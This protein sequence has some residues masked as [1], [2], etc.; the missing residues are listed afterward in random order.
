MGL[1]E[2][3]TLETQDT[4]VSTASWGAKMRFAFHRFHGFDDLEAE[5]SWKLEDL[6]KLFR[7]IGNSLKN[8]LIL[9]RIL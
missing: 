4:T 3:L 8:H 1:K 6:R 5:T 2:G 9:S 7:F